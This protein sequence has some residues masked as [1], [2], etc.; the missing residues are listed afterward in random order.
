MSICPL[1]ISIFYYIGGYI[2][3]FIIM[4]LI[5]LILCFFSRNIPLKEISEDPKHGF[6]FYLKNKVIKNIQEYKIL[7]IFKYF[8]NLI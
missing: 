7:N 8:Y 5:S 2:L 4:F 6:F 1:I 3:P